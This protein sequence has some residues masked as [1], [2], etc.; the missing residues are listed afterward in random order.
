MMN[1]SYTDYVAD[2]HTDDGL[3]TYVV[4]MET[5]D[6][7]WEYFVCEA[8]DAD[9]ASEQA[10]N[11]YPD[12]KELWINRGLNFGMENTYD[13]TLMG[14]TVSVNAISP[15]EALEIACDTLNTPYTEVD[16]STVSVI[17]TNIL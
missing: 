17:Q 11:A 5:P 10:E 2:Q 16:S 9:H 12:Y 6:N 3:F 15:D 4:I 14:I 8:E 7:Y 13:V 1:N